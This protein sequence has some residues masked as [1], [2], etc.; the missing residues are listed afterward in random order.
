MN[1]V[2]ATASV[3]HNN[4]KAVAKWKLRLPS[5]AFKRKE[6]INKIFLLPTVLELIQKIIDGK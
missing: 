1:E 4:F 2:A 5:L 6:A 3:M